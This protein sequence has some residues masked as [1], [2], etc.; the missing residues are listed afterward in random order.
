VRRF[1]PLP[2]GYDAGIMGEIAGHV[3]KVLGNVTEDRE[4]E[5]EGR[6]EEQTG[7]K[8]DHEQVEAVEDEVQ[9]ARGEKHQGSAS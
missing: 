2:R 8:P 1:P 6:A 4:V 3:K 5:A 7:H 9:E